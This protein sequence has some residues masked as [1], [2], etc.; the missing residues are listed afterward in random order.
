M[1]LQFGSYFSLADQEYIWAIP[2]S[3][4]NVRTLLKIKKKFNKKFNFHN[5]LFFLLFLKLYNVF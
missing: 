4:R 5:G 1:K 2:G 3:R